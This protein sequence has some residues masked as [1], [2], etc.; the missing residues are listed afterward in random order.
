MKFPDHLD[1]VAASDGLRPRRQKTNEPLFG[2]AH[3]IEQRLR[4]LRVR[5]KSSG[6]EGELG[7]AARFVGDM[8][9]DDRGGFGGGVTSVFPRPAHQ[10]TLQLR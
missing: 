6:K 1:N 8:A 4:A 3:W 2:D 7:L 9:L 5:M 10:F